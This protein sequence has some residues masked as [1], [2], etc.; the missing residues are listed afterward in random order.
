MIGESG[1]E[2]CIISYKKRIASLGSMQD[3]GC[4]GL[5]HWDVPERW[6]GEGGERGVQDGEHVYN[7]QFSK[8]NSQCRASK[9]VRQT[10]LEEQGEIDEF[11]LRAGDM[12]ILLSYI[13]RSSR[14][15]IS[16]NIAELKSTNQMD[17]TDRDC[18]IQQQ[19]NTHFSSSHGIFTK[20]GHIL[21]HKTH[22]N[23][24]K[25]ID[26]INNCSQI[27]IKLD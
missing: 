19:Q 25:R 20:T 5:V 4:L 24:C 21:G 26:F 2:T 3:T 10:L 14:Q 11:T 23:K 27:I 1:I 17:I 22:L 13:D 6:Y 9:Y 15:K 18:F 16:K 7:C 12:N 8:Q